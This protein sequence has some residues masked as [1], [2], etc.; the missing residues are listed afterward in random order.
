MAVA[1]PFDEMIEIADAARSNHRHRN[2]IGQGTGQGD[3]ESLPGAVPVH[4]REQNLTGAQRHYFARIG[5]GVDAGRIAAAMGENLPAVRF[6][7]LCDALGVDRDHD[8]LVAELFRGLFD[9]A[10]PRHRGGIDRDLV[11]PGS[12]QCADILDGPDA[13]AH[14]ER[15]EAGL[16][17][18]PHH[19][20]H[21]AAVLMARRD[22][23]KSK[24]VG[25][26]PIIGDRRRD[27]IAGIT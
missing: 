18:A 8:A 26:R 16:R 19:L 20:E 11:G 17:G 9:E 10:A 14:G 6:A 27:R 4:G 22:V 1:D 5:D 13:A 3:I 24:L 2:S 21:D 25:A 23:H 7:R 12:E 15:H